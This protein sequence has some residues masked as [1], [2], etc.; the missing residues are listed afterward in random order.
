MLVSHDTK[1]PARPELGAPVRTQTGA[2]RVTCRTENDADPPGAAGCRGPA[3]A[4][5][6]ALAAGVCASWALSDICNKH[7][8]SVHR[9]RAPTRTMSTPCTTLKG[10]VAALGVR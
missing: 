4:H 7:L 3:S 5:S 1:L 10:T 8:L 6:A 2:E 9:A